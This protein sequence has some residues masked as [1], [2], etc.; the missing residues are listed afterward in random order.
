[1]VRKGPKSERHEHRV[2]PRR[3]KFAFGLSWAIQLHL[4]I[5][6]FWVSRSRLGFIRGFFSGQSSAKKNYTE[7]HKRIRF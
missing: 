7:Q 2:P 5:Q 1:M 6:P 3:K 4:A